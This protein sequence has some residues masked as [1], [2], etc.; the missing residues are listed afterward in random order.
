MSATKK[1]PLLDDN[2]RIKS[3]NIEARSASEQYQPEG[4]ESIW[5]SMIWGPQD[6]RPLYWSNTVRAF[7]MEL[8]GVVLFALVTNMAASLSAATASALLSGVLVGVLGGGS[9]YMATSWIRTTKEDYELPRHL[10]W[11][12][13]FGHFF[14]SRLGLIYLLFYLVV[15]LLVSAVAG[16]LLNMLGNGVVPAS[17]TSTL[18]TGNSWFTEVMGSALIVFS[19]L[20]N[21]YLSYPYDKEDH[22]TFHGQW[23][24]ALMR[25][26]WTA[27]FFSKGAYTFDPV[28]YFAGAI[29]TCSTACLFNAGNGWWFYFFVCLI[30]SLGGTLLYWLLIAIYGSKSSRGPYQVKMRKQ[31]ER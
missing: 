28:I 16:G 26:L 20:Y 9:Y 13:S 4:R 22:H 31:S 6:E 5:Y 1:T 19:V 3:K 14:A 23:L 8:L 11:S 21:N 18:T 10:S 15:Q 30:G 24:G 12:V 7:I 17:L 25:A 27:I 29:G 2:K